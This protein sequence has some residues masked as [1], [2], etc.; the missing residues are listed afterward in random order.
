MVYDTQNHWLSGLYSSFR[1]LNTRKHNVSDTR[2][3]QA[4]T[5]S[6][7][8]LRR[9]TSQRTSVASCSLCCS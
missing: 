9:N 1:I 4:A 7:R 3:A 8:T 6:R 2:S 5:S